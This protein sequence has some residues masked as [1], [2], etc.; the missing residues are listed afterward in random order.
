MRR[1]VPRIGPF[2]LTPAA[3]ASWVR[4]GLLFATSASGIVSARRPADGSEA[5][6]AD[7]GSPL[8]AD[9]SVDSDLLVA[10]TLTRWV[11]G[12]SSV[13]GEILWRKQLPQSRSETPF[14]SFS[15]RLSPPIRIG[16]VFPLRLMLPSAPGPPL[17][18]NHRVYV[19]GDDGVLYFLDPHT[20]LSMRPPQ[21][22]IGGHPAGAPVAD[23][24]HVYITSAD[25]LLAAYGPLKAALDWKK[26]EKVAA[27]TGP[28]LGSDLVFMPLDSGAVQGYRAQD[29]Q[30]VATLPAPPMTDTNAQLATPA[31]LCT[32]TGESLHL[33]TV[34]DTTQSWSMTVYGKGV[35]TMTPLMT[36][37]GRPMP[38]LDRSGGSGQR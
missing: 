25:G 14:P 15:V 13:N 4:G 12:A 24:Q 34:I 31:V 33:V 37:P 21:R 9:P 26:T 22:L 38:P 3:L 7:F 6:H 30:L 10:A 20:G 36:L 18:A 2:R 11:I 27:R 5:W 29:G 23:A 35:L 8:S 28:L 19:T 16:T 17:V 1:R 32:G